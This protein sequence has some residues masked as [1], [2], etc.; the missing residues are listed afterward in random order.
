MTNTNITKEMKNS[1]YAKEAVRRIYSEIKD[2]RTIAKMVTEMLSKREVGLFV[3]EA[4]VKKF[5]AEIEDD[6]LSDEKETDILVDKLLK[7][8]GQSLDGNQEIK[9]KKEKSL[10]DKNSPQNH[11]RFCE[12]LVDKEAEGVV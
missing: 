11:L 5:I 6:S 3:S 4:T 2:V 8:L 10:F 1:M 7:S 12:V 9:E